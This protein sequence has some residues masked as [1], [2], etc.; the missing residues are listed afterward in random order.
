M[1]QR[2][3]GKGLKA[4]TFRFRIESQN[5]SGIKGM[6]QILFLKFSNSTIPE[7]LNP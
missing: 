2:A 3:W 4:K 1:G 6:D 7:F 5:N